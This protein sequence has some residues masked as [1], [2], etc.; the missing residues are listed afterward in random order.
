MFL[1]STLALQ[2]ALCELYEHYSFFSSNVHTIHTVRLFFAFK[3]NM[4]TAY[5]SVSLA[6]HTHTNTHIHPSSQ[7]ASQPYVPHVRQPHTNTQLPAQFIDLP[8]HTDT[9]YMLV[10][11]G[12]RVYKQSTHS[13]R[14][15]SQ[16]AQWACMYAFHV[17]CVCTW[18]MCTQTVCSLPIT[19]YF[20]VSL[21]FSSSLCC[22]EP[23]TILRHYCC[24]SFNLSHTHVCIVWPVDKRSKF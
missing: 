21:G 13:K 6:L 11:F 16:F 15:L 3:T 7:S 8:R 24:L 19:L 1:F 9:I 14:F 10:W 18:Q 17:I 2:R 12:L 4:H 23:Y 20:H 22:L 5:C